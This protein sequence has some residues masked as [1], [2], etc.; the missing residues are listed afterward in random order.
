[1][2]LANLIG[3]IISSLTSLRDVLAPGTQKKTL[4]GM[5]GQV[6]KET[7]RLCTVRDDEFMLNVHVLSV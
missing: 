1:M 7:R 2:W 6:F 5:E 4:F 3:F